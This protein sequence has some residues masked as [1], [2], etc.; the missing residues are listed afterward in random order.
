PFDQAAV[1]RVSF[2]TVYH[3]LVQRAQIARGESVL[4]LGAGGA[5]GAAAIQ[6]A[7]ALGAG[8]VIASASTPAKRQVA[9]DAGADAAIDSKAADWRD[10]IKA[11]TGG[12]GVDIVVDPIGDAATEPAF[13]SLA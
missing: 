5:I 12:R 1:F 13:R 4:V 3:A 10:Q 9:L 7:K 8:Q 6:M 11:L 2:G